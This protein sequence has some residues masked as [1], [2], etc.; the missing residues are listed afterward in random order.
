LTTSIWSSPRFAEDVSEISDE[1]LVDL[2]GSMYSEVSDT[3]D[4]P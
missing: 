4:D 2:L 3:D 1:K